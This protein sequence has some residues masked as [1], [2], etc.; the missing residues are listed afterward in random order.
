MTRSSCLSFNRITRK[1]FRDESIFAIECTGIKQILKVVRCCFFLLLKIR[2]DFKE[3]K[4]RLSDNHDLQLSPFLYSL[5]VSARF[6]RNV[7][8]MC[9]FLRLFDE[10][11]VMREEQ[12]DV[13]FLEIERRQFYKKDDYDMV[14][15]RSP[16]YI[17]M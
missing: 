2:H 6:V 13:Y 10:E 9:V 4:I 17:G 14:S 7:G 11:F 12:F 3:Y 1:Y 5:F 15:Q 8:V 16:R